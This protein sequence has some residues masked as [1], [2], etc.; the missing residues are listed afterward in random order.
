MQKDVGIVPKPL[1]GSAFL[2]E[3]FSVKPALNR[4]SCGTRVEHL[5]PKAMQLLVFMAEHSGE[6]LS[7]EVLL[8]AIW[9]DAFVTDQVL[10]NT[11]SH[12]RQAFGNDGKDYIQTIPKGGYLL[13]V[14]P[15]PASD[16]ESKIQPDASAAS[17]AIGPDVTRAAGISPPK[18]SSDLNAHGRHPRLMWFVLLVGVSVL[19]TATY[20]YLAHERSSATPKIRSLAVLPIKNLSSDP[21]QEFFA[22]GMTDALIARLSQIRSLKITSRTSVMH[23]KN[24]SET[25]PKI[26][27][28]LGVQGILEASVLRVGNRV[29]V[30][31][32]LID[33]QR[34]R[35]LWA[36]TYERDT[37]DVL[38]LQSELAQAI[39]K[40]IRLQL[41]PEETEQLKAAR[42]VNP[43][44]Y[45]WYLKG[46]QYLNNNRPK[47]ATEAYSEA[48]K[49]DPQFAEAYLALGRSYIGL[50]Q[51]EGVPPTEAL[52]KA[53]T[54]LNRALELDPTLAQVNGPLA[55]IRAQY[56]YDWQGA[57][58]AVRRQLEL[59]PDSE[60]AHLLYGSFVLVP[61]GR[62]EE[63]IAELRRAR[64]LAPAYP[65]Y[66]SMLGLGLYL[67]RRNDDAIRELQ[68]SLELDEK[69]EVSHEL[70]GMAYSARGM[71]QKAI[72]ELERAEE[73]NSALPI[74]E[75][76][77]RARTLGR[78]GYVY[79][80]A[81]EKK[82]AQGV[83]EELK[84]ISQTR[85]VASYFFATIHAPLGNK[86]QA[87]SYL[88][89]AYREHCMEMMFLKV[90][91]R[92]DTLRS[93]TR[94]QDLL[95]R[96][97]L[98]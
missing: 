79:A 17:S 22:D 26:A 80:A 92:L 50:P 3:R 86:D 4:V 33:A 85:Y 91:P 41:T 51:K 77:P 90:D 66:R 84:K 8:N 25:T 6:V 12:I 45:D 67:A 27:R 60:A 70:L 21:E 98:K 57:E 94:F 38:M 68:Q 2:I 24:T 76:G 11:I 34:D 16:N 78:L 59:N 42:R 61:Q 53:L 54:A 19:L 43:E 83:I 37:A 13:N 48:V 23:Y 18:N 39:A 15:L 93:D 74:A 49:L 55:A 52:P 97:N 29:R 46:S 82:R 71:H 32:Q 75:F 5:E 73:L 10:S 87:F 1:S 20:F 69:M 58:R 96:T 89:K 14:R 7:R 30:T 95:R 72:Q 35:H 56:E 81:G 44:A 28:E 9:G 36:N 63:G 88:E 62:F 40:E 31:A 65:Y 47:K 64:D